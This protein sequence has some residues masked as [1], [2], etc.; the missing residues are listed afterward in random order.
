[1]TK[2]ILYKETAYVNKGVNLPSLVF[3]FLLT[4]KKYKSWSASSDKIEG[5]TEFK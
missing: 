1:M 2:L 3:L 4:N 5:W